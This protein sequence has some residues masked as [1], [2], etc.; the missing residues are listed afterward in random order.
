MSRAQTH[1]WLFYELMWR[2]AG[3]GATY[4]KP[5]WVQQYFRRWVEP[6]DGGLFGSKEAAFASN[7]H[8]RYWNMIG[9]KDHHQ[10]SLVGQAG[11]VE[12]VYDHYAVGFFLFDPLTRRLD[13]PQNPVRLADGPALTQGLE[14]HDL[15]VVLT[16]YRTSSGIL[17]EHKALATTQGARQRSIVLLRLRVQAPPDLPSQPWLCISISPFGPT[18]FERHDKAGRLSSDNRLTHLSYD[19]QDRCLQIGNRMG[20]VFDSAP[21]H[22]GLYGNAD[23]SHDPNHYLRVNPFRDLETHGT[24]NG[25]DEASDHVAGLV[26]GVF[27]WP[28]ATTAHGALTLDIRLPVDDYRGASDLAELIATPADALEQA[29]HDFWRQKLRVSG[30]QPLLP[31]ALAH[32]GVLFRI[33][34]SHLLILADHG[35]I[36]PGPTIYD[37][38]WVRDSS[39]EG[40]ACALSGD[41]NLPR[42]QFGTHYP[43][44]FNRGPGWIGPAR[45]HGFFGGAH[46][47][48]DH[49]WDSNGQALWAIGRFDRILGPSERFG[50]GL[51]FPYVLEGARWIRDNRSPYGLLHSGWSAEHLGDKHQ[52]HYW[53]DLWALAGLW[54]AAKLAERIGAHEVGELWAIYDDV[55]RATSD[56]IRWVLAEQSRR[57]Y[58][59]T[60]IP[61]GPGDVGRL[62]STMIGALAYFHPCR[63]DQGKR[64]GED[65]DWAAR[66]T[67]ETIWSHFVRDGGFRHDSAWFCFGPYLTL[68]LAHAFLLI[69]DLQRMD[70]CLAWSIGNAGYASVSHAVGDGRWSVTQGAWNEQ[71]C[72]PIASDF[73]EV[74]ER[75]WYMGDIPHGW[76]AAEFLMLL[77][78]ILL[79]ESDEDSDPH[80]DLAAGLLPHWLKDGESVGVHNAPT[81]FGTPLSYRLTVDRTS[82]QVRI[83]IDQ[84]PA[85][86]R[87]VY[88]C[89]FGEISSAQADGK[90]IPSDTHHAFIPA[91]AAAITVD[92]R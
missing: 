15:P 46:E 64:L 58:W 65:I 70:Q 6:F 67:L 34:R 1:E 22:H 47:K 18:G 11:E 63:L 71:H 4:P 32:L 89:R 16:R 91:G 56:S 29:N 26:T 66:M 84:A 72:D 38:F 43:T 75:W 85:G 30:T 82:Q 90:P 41:L 39:V 77:R 37:A 51:Y 42:Q 57:G 83:Q 52:P 40:I 69:G 2:A 54:E 80:I 25:H 92:Y 53:D 62:D 7:A 17:V 79:S 76:A 12:P 36:H 61:T 28:L 3:S 78:D 60:F 45:L 44:V 10:E 49:E 88:P 23:G 68:Q 20:P 55:R 81:L 9:V 33:C 21:A 35:Q 13:L 73:A 24:L 87:L 14:D 8:Y 59:E 5:W 31:A 74:P 48:N 19:H 86:V 50:A 27:A